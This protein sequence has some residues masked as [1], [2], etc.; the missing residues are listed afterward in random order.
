MAPVFLPGLAGQQDWCHEN[1]AV[2]ATRSQ[3]R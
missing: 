1:P 3:S 2:N